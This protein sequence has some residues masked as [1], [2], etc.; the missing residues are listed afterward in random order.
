MEDA[1]PGQRL[2]GFDPSLVKSLVLLAGKCEYFGQLSF[3]YKGDIP[4][5]GQN[6]ILLYTQY[7]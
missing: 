5:L 4:L 3:K 1:Q 7:R 6:A 2:Y